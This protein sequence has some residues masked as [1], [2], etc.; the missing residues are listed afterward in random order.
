MGTAKT[1]FAIIGLGLSIRLVLAFFG[2][3]GGDAITYIFAWA[4]YV[5]PQG[6]FMEWRVKRV[7]W[8]HPLLSDGI[9]PSVDYWANPNHEN[10][11][12]VCLYTAYKSLGSLNFFEITALLL[13]YPYYTLKAI[14]GMLRIIIKK[15]LR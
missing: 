9:T 12:E 8:K 3:G 2:K 6:W 10:G 13:L 7:G 4:F 1:I 5:I 15:I 14:L 11:K